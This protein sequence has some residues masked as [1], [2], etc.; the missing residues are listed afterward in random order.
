MCDGEFEDDPLG[1]KSVQWQYMGI[2]HLH[3]LWLC[4][5]V[6]LIFYLHYHFIV[7][8]M[9][10]FLLVYFVICVLVIITYHTTV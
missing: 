6:T 9:I 10:H 1:D 4:R 8:E 7:D 5:I 2:S 3:L